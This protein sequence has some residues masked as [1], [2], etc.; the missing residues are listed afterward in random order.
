VINAHILEKYVQ[1]Y[2]GETS[3]K[4]TT[5]ETQTL[6]REYYYNVHVLKKRCGRVWTSLSWFRIR[7]SGGLIW[8]WQWTITF[9][10]LRE[11][12]WL[13]EELLVSQARLCYMELYFYYMTHE[14]HITHAYNVRMLY[15]Y[16]KGQ[17]IT[18]QHSK[19]KELVCSSS[20]F[21]FTI[22]IYSTPIKVIQS[23][24]KCQWCG[25]GQARIQ[26]QHS[27]GCGAEDI[28]SHNWL[29][30]GKEI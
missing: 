10:K 2:G 30:S 28:R 11:I 5:C 19:Y 13:A 7:A 15:I 27:F 25:K 4:K 14:K 21:I 6:I 18:T 24:I 26:E 8:T 20:L 12:S 1:G 29:V 23:L 17:N 22:H 9:H 3:R 16:L